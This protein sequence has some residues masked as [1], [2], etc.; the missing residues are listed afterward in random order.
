LLPLSTHA[1]LNFGLGPVMFWLL[2]GSILT[3]FGLRRSAGKEVDDN[4]SSL[5]R[6]AVLPRSWIR[7]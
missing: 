7:N 1:S 3:M 4:A 5:G 6:G 2:S